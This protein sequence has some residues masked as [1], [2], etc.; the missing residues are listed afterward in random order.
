MTTV[1]FDTMIYDK[2]LEHSLRE[3]LMQLKMKGVEYLITQVQVDEIAAIKDDKKEKRHKLFLLVVSLQPKIIK[4]KGVI[5]GVTRLGHAQLYKDK[6]SIKD[7]IR[8]GDKRLNPS[9]DALI[10]FTAL[11]SAEIYVTNDKTRKNIIE[12]IVVK[13]GL[14]KKI[15]NFEK[16]QKWIELQ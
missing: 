13:D 16:F 9:R 1:M 7:K 10:G 14:N 12:E 8:K 5:L 11:K 6:T 2:I 15:M 4:T 3:K